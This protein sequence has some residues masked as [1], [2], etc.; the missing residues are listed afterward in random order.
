MK[1]F[2]L[3]NDRLYIPSWL[4]PSEAALL[5]LLSCPF[6]VYAAEFRVV[7]KLT[8]NG[9]AVLKSSAEVRGLLGISTGTPYAALDIVS[10]GTASNVYAQIWRNGSGVEVA[11]MTSEGTLYATVAKGDNLGSHTATQNLDMAQHSVINVASVAMA[12]DGLRITTSVFAGASGVFI[13]TGGAIQTVGAGYGPVVGNARGMGAVDLQTSRSAATQVASEEFAVIGGGAKNTASGWGAISGGGYLN[14]ASGM[15]TVIAGGTENTASG[16]GTTIGGG[17]YNIAIDVGGTIGGGTW[18]SVS[19]T[20]STVAGGED[21]VASYWA[22]AVGGGSYNLASGEASTIAGGMDNTASGR[23]S[24][25]DGGYENS[26]AGDYSWAFGYYSSSTAN[27][28]F[29]RSDSQGVQT[30]NTVV[31][32]TL[33]KNRGGFLITGSTNPAMTGALDRGMFVTGN[34]LVGISTG[35]PYAA[36]DVVSSGTAS[37]IY[38]QIWRNGSG[39]EVASMTSQ[40]KLF[41]DGSGLTGISTSGGGDSLGTH[42]ATQTLNMAQFP[43]VNVSSLAM[44][45]DGL[46]ITT[47]VFAGASGIFISNGG[48]IQTVGAGDGPVVG[49][50]RGVG[51]VDLQT[52]RDY[53]AQVASGDFSV[54]SGGDDNEATGPESTVGGGY[55]NSAGAQAATVSGGYGNSAANYAA[56]IGGG[57][58]NVAGNGGATVGGGYRNQATGDSSMIGGGGDNVA[59][60]KFATIAGGEVNSASGSWDATVS[61]GWANTAG[62]DEATVSGGAN[63][64][65][66]GYAAGVSGGEDNSASGDYSSVSGGHNNLVS[67]EYSGVAGGNYNFVYGSSSFVG[68]GD[69]NRGYNYYSAVVGG[70]SNW[71]YAN[72]S[73]VGGGS[74]NGTYGEYSS[75]LGGINNRAYGFASSVVAGDRAYAAGDYSFAGGRG[76]SSTAA[77]AFTWADSRSNSALTINSVADRTLFKNSGGFLITGSTNTN[78]TGAKDRGM[79]VT[80]SGLVGISTGVPYAAL[81]VVSTGTASNIYAQIWRNGSGVEVASMTSTGV[82]YATIPNA[83]GDNLGDHTAT[84]D[85][86]MAQFP[87]VNVSSL[88]MVGD[89]I[90]IATSVYAGASGIFISTSGQVMTLGPGTGTVPPGA[91]GLGAVDLQTYRTAAA[92]VAS[93]PYSVIAGGEENTAVEWDDVVSGGDYNT[94]S[95]GESVVAGGYNNTAG[96][97]DSAVSGGYNNSAT[98]ETSV[99]SGGN[100]NTSSGGESVIAGGSNNAADGAWAVIGGGAYN[101]ANYPNATVSGGMQNYAN[102]DF[103][104]IPGGRNNS[105]TNLY[106]LAAGYAAQSTS[107]GTFTWADSQ[108]VGVSNNVIDR[109]VF[110]NRGGFKITAQTGVISA[111]LAMLEVVS[112]GTLSTQYAQIW[113]DSTGLVVASM[114]ANGKLSTL[115]PL[116]GDNLGNHTATQDLLLGGNDIYNASTITATGDITAARYQINGSTVLAVLPGTGSFGVGPGAGRVNAVGG[117]YNVYVG[118]DAGYS[119][120]T[121][122][123]NVFVGY[124][125]GH[126]NTTGTD[127]VFLGE[128][129]GYYN[130]SGNWNFYLGTR[131]GIHSTSNDN[132]FIGSDSGYTNTTGSQN[133]FIGSSAGTSNDTGSENIFMGYYAG[134]YNVGG[135]K[136]TYVGL[137]SGYQNVSGQMNSIFGYK[138]GLGVSGNSY[139]SNSLFG[140]YAGKALT[141][142]SNNLLLGWQAGDALTSG[143]SNIVIGYNQDAS[144]PTA[145]NELNIGGVLYGDLSAKTIGISTRAPQA[146]LD[147]VS[148]GTASNIYAQIWRDGSG[149]VVSSMTSTGVLYPSV[150][151]S[152]NTK[153]AKTGDTMTG[154]L[155]LSSTTI[156]PSSVTL[157]GALNVVNGNVGIGTTGP[158]YHLQVESSA[159][160]QFQVT[161]LGTSY[162]GSILANIYS[163]RNVAGTDALLQVGSAYAPNTLYV[164]DSG[165]VG[166]GNAAPAGALEVSNSYNGTSQGGE[167]YITNNYS[168]G[169]GTRVADLMFRLT[170]SVGTRKPA[171]MIQALSNNQDSSTGDNLLFYTRTADATPTEKVR[172]DNNGNVGIGTTT[173]RSIL[174]VREAGNGSYSYIQGGVLGGD[175]TAFGSADTI[176]VVSGNGF[177]GYNG[178]ALIPAIWGGSATAD[179]HNVIYIGGTQRNS[180]A[181][182]ASLAFANWGYFTGTGSLAGGLGNAVAQADAVKFHFE[183]ADLGSAFAQSL[184]LRSRSASGTDTNAL[185]VLSN[186]SVGIGMAAP[187]GARLV[188]QNS[189]DGAPALQFVTTGSKPA[190]AAAYRGAMFYAQSASGT[191]DVL[192][193]CMKMSTDA[194]QWVQAAIG[195]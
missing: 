144:A 58:Q 88:A 46:R 52:S 145:S 126:N 17:G 99:V 2:S 89:G 92:Q 124:T 189:G 5:L 60:G 39:V 164:Q 72:D 115:Q 91:R 141:T 18:N 100:D 107:S 166:I 106:S 148:T 93:G 163:Q 177:D 43:V 42:I 158:T 131:A 168:S 87:V 105:V 159:N 170:D 183:L 8:S 37:N 50:A 25:I 1:S 186:G 155:Y 78:M 85:L 14:N 26:A 57:E 160:N 55:S 111:N 21:N 109:T 64:A 178:L 119:N 19:D 86:N 44:V 34:G 172:I 110:K 113:R 167:L 169:S 74:S 180:G 49:N 192:Y 128:E 182:S 6:T 184:T 114:T 193:I 23:W 13:S 54:V 27:G 150:S 188:V 122:D 16:W 157:L 30:D 191:A 116:P 73:F 29:T 174:H 133:M 129:A 35:V 7:D 146:A 51:A 61:G 63:N 102:G 134:Y 69:N 143:A 96:G 70:E 90:R 185:T 71:A 65:A 154:A 175:G 4:A 195:N 12:G 94:A 53:P 82:L 173:P 151:G 194:Y 138:A 66:S 41:A 33:F 137:E 103:S 67:G 142:G 165:N 38:V 47:S 59:S 147:I 48:A 149:N 132:I 135:L 31:D 28:T 187:A 56:T 112:T 22:A 24:A 190:C 81:D 136:N 98:G 121:G 77:G 9:Y 127:N 171:A 176:P 40:G 118:K 76:S 123:D 108:G 97:Y 20:A 36:L 139:S 75:I 68:G 104:S 161:G 152:D 162:G 101:Q 179:A 140:Y 45:G 3:G 80:G 125:A 11:S 117:N 84:Q 15:L 130:V 153:V 120:T 181:I 10:T 79:L 156:S 62:N 83:G 32:R 95:G